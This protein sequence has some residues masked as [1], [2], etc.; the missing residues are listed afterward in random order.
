[1]AQYS[2]EGVSQLAVA[3]PQPNFDIFVKCKN[4]YVCHLWNDIFVGLK[5]ILAHSYV[6]GCCLS[7]T[8]LYSHCY[9]AVTLRWS[10]ASVAST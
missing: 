1:M 8:K 9:V 2:P 3:C 4:L 6:I 5:G 7:T 10:G